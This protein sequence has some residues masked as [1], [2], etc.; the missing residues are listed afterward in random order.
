M[1]KCFRDFFLKGDSKVKIYIY[2]L[3]EKIWNCLIFIKLYYIKSF[4]KKN[5]QKS[6]RKQLVLT[7]ASTSQ[8]M[9]RF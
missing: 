8:N 4:D 2:G 6:M 9:T 3:I 1:K 7:S 5:K